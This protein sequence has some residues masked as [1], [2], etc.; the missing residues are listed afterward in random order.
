MKKIK[1]IGIIT[2]FLTIVVLLTETLWNGTVTQLER[3]SHGE[4]KKTEQLQLH[5]EEEDYDTVIE[6]E[7]EE[8]KYTKEEAQDMLDELLEKLDEIVLGENVS[9]DRVEK[10]LHLVTSVS[11]YP[12]DIRW[13]LSSYHVLGI[14]GKINSSQVPEDGIVVELIGTI[15]YEE[16]ES[17]YIQNV[18]IYPPTRDKEEQFIYE[19][20]KEIASIQKETREDTSFPLPQEVQGK[21]IVWSKKKE[22][23]WFYVPLLGLGVAAYVVYR[24]R[25]RIRIKEQRREELLL[26]GYP[27]FI[28]KLT[29]LLGCGATVKYAWERIV[30]NYE[31]QKDIKGTNLLYEEIVMTL[32]EIQSGVSEAE[33]Y[34]RF[35]KRCGISIYL[36]FGTLLSQN[37]RKGSQ[38]LVDIFKM[39]SIQSFENRKSR[40]RRLGEEA[41]TKLLGPMFGMLV[42]VFV[43]VMV[44]AFLSMQL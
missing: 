34:E 7:I 19:V 4:G 26:R 11:G 37:L 23:T 24:E 1:W 29:M 30:Q 33:A 41:S 15:S 43:V 2:I 35:G 42:V 22:K 8:Q 18:V 27:G 20:E 3:N 44:P 13:E 17:I 39:E 25:K 9:F 38:G 10:D 36:K 31:K 6:M 28:S 16:M 14:D 21:R 32:R 40:A 5:L 12:M